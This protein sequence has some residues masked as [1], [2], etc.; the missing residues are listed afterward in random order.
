MSDAL[1]PI[2]DAQA[3]AIA[4]TMK[5]ARSITDVIRGVGSYAKDIAGDLPHQIVGGLRDKVVAYRE[6]EAFRL[7]GRTSSI[8]QDRGVDKPIE[9]APKLLLPILEA[10]TEEGSPEVRD[11]WAKL[12]AAAMDPTRK[13]QVRYS[14][15]ETL[16][17]FD[18]LDVILLKARYERQ[19]DLS[20]NPREFMVNHLQK[21]VD[22]IQVSM[23]NLERGRCVFL[24]GSNPEFDLTPY[25]REL[26]LACAD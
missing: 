17:Q 15:I 23:V 6:Q 21:S 14:F 16:K 11:L 20:P 18:P 4:E 10:A 25:G 2:T 22:E 3:N 12:L 13:N 1:M 5:T 7:F 9:P 19:G 24:A 8:L 26:I